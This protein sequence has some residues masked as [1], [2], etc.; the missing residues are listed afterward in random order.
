MR[1]ARVRL[2]CLKAAALIKEGYV[3][4]CPVAHA[5]TIAAYGGLPPMNHDLWTEQ[6][7]AFLRLSDELWVY[8]IPGW[9]ESKGVF[10]EVGEAIRLKMPIK[11]LDDEGDET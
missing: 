7:L 8:C 6:D 4:F 11:Y 2:V 1:E 9:D 10:A 5:H 3:V